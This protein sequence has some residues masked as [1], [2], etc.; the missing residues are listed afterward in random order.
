[1]AVFTVAAGPSGYAQAANGAS[2][3]WSPGSG[4]VVTVMAPGQTSNWIYWS[5]K[6][7]AIPPGLAF[8]GVNI[9]GGCDFTSP[10]GARVANLYARVSKTLDFAGAGG[11][12]IDSVT[13]NGVGHQTNATIGGSGITSDDLISG[14]IFI[15]LAANCTGVEAGNGTFRTAAFNWILTFGEPPVPP[16]GTIGGKL[17]SPSGNY[18]PGK[19]TG[20]QFAALDYNL[21]QPLPQTFLSITWTIT[22]PAGVKFV[23]TNNQSF[24][25]SKGTGG[26]PAD[27]YHGNTGPISIA[28]GTPA[29]N[30][31]IKCFAQINNP[32]SSQTLVGNLNVIQSPGGMLSEF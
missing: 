32:N 28:Q 2:S 21:T 12:Q 25:Q 14:S 30:Y 31:T 22:A 17:T 16:G 10:G 3:G 19:V 5:V 18:L 4:N 8:T 15:G 1:M 7:T 6:N 24:S 11:T 23:N 26:D 9:Q 29:G 27:P 13:G 20:Q